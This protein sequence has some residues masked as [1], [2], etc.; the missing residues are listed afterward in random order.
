M[1]F[2][3]SWTLFVWFL[4]GYKQ[5]LFIMPYHAIE[6]KETGKPEVLQEVTVAP[7]TQKQ[8][9]GPVVCIVGDGNAAHVLIPL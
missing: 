6:E 2:L 5:K 4:V 8:K 1:H 7:E 9:D 3:S